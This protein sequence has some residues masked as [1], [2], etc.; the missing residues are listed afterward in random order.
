MNHE[1]HEGLWVEVRPVALG[2]FAER[3][4]MTGSWCGGQFFVSDWA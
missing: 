4:A 3:L 1:A 2:C